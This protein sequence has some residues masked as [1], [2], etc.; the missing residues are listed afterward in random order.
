V[1]VSKKGGSGMKTI[2]ELIEWLG[3][4]KISA[5]KR[6]NETYSET[7]EYYNQIVAILTK[8]QENE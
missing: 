4:I 1:W 3:D 6:E 7:L 5:M 8:E 2:Q